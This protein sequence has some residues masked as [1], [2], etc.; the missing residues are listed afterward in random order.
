MILARA[1]VRRPDGEPLVDLTV[2]V[3]VFRHLPC[4][5]VVTSS[6]AAR[7]ARVTQADTGSLGDEGSIFVT[8]MWVAIES[9]RAIGAD[10]LGSV[11]EKAPL[12]VLGTPVTVYQDSSGGQN[13]RSA[14][15][16]NRFGQ[17]RNRFRGYHLRGGLV[18]AEHGLR[19]S[20]IVVLSGTPKAKCRPLLDISGRIFR[21]RPRRTNG[22]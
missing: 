1:G 19:A 10:V 15:H 8:E 18:T 13:W 20:P 9:V 7:A 3:Q 2:R 6:S 17:V 21:L 12:K 22:V 14:A 11:E 4:A 16:V 5:F